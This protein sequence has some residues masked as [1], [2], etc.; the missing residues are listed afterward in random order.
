MQNRLASR[1]FFAFSLALPLSTG[2]LLAEA[3]T[4]IHTFE[5]L[6]IDKPPIDY[7]SEGGDGPI[8]RFNRKIETEGLKLEYSDRFGYLPAVLTELEIPLASQLLRFSS[9]SVHAGVINRKTPRAYYFNDDVV[10]TWFPGA[11]HLEV[12]AQDSQ[13]GTL[14]YTLSNTPSVTPQFSRANGRFCMGCHNSQGWH[15]SGFESPGH[16]FR[17]SIA[18]SL[19]T[20][21]L[22]LEQRWEPWYVSAASPS[23]PHKGVS[24]NDPNDNGPPRDIPNEDTVKI[25]CYPASTSDALAHLILDHQLLGQNMLSRL[26]NEHYLN[27]RSK[28]E[29][30]AVRYLLLA[31]EAPMN[32]PASGNSAFAKEYQ[33]RGPK[34]RSGRSLHD[35]NLKTRLYQHRIS[36]LIHSQ[37]MRN[38]PPEMRR[39]LFRRL[40]DVI[41]GREKLKDFSIDEADRQDT[42][43]ILREVIAD[44]PL[45]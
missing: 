15:H 19:E 9:H 37:V 23:L 32:N 30:M 42:L 8:A 26:S 27:V 31:D 33:S 25:E 14:F 1:W 10:V 40:N 2:L 20:H 41:T 16:I 35:L 22:P 44:W 24:L 18:G 11:A 43:A 17:S 6:P 4:K 3:P 36:P 12:A 39:S 13:R 45:E 28:V 5:R 34:A 38:Q 7:W 29:N 21:A